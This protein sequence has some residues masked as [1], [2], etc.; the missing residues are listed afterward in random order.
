NEDYICWTDGLSRPK[1]FSI[2][3][4]LSGAYGVVTESIVNAAKKQPLDIAVAEY[5]HDAGR[6]TNG[7]RNALFQFT[8]RWVFDDMEKSTWASYS[9]TPMP[10][11]VEDSE[12]DDFPD[13][14]NNVLN[15]TV[16]SG[17]KNVVAVEIAV[18]KS[19]GG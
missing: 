9:K 7:L 3:K 14:K 2:D 17:D 15:V 19:I 18:R 12:D 8:Y 4:M 5:D 10:K 16:N 13:G 1:K 11:R 6:K